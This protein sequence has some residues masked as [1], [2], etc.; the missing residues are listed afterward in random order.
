[1]TA[2]AFGP[3]P[4]PPPEPGVAG[5]PILPAPPIPPPVP[6]AGPPLGTLDFTAYART[7]AHIAACSPLG[8]LPERFDPRIIESHCSQLAALQE[9]WRQLWLAQARP[10]LAS[11]VP[12]DLPTTVVYPF[13]GG[14]LL[15]ALVTF[16]K[17][18]EIT[19]LSLEP[20][21]D[22][23]TVDALTPTDL[24]PMLAEVR[25]KINHLFHYGHSKTIDMGKM[26][27]SK[28]PGDLTYTLV[29]LE[30]NQLDPVAVRFFRVDPHG[31]LQYLTQ[32]DLDA[33]GE[34]KLR[35][36]AF[37]NMEIEFVPRGGGPRRIFR[38]IAANLDDAH[39]TADP[40]VLRHLEG[41][42]PI[43]AITKAASYLLWWKEF[44]KIRNYLLKNMVWMISD[45]TG[46]PTDDAVA[47][48]FEQIPYGRFDGPFL[49]G[50]IRP[51][52]VFRKL[53]AEK[54]QPLAFRFGY[55][56]IANHDHLL[57]TRRITK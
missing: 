54:A 39:L 12:K 32:N 13:G 9:R 35:R 34:P 53:W 41:K 15:T 18:T 56:D 6:T 40:S 47:N 23:R 33:T 2:A 1:M 29:A 49:G 21:G 36:A 5:A 10:F 11:V 14:D 55:P 30:M 17:A 38:H 27:R 44:S 46:I 51:T 25:E 3:I 26:A 28:L 43:A 20:A 31:V 24:E 7:L 8:A 22:P 52:E 48:G 45:S 42:G 37:S 50:G 57:I 19:T 16:P 4:P